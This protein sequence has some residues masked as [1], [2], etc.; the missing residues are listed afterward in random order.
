M[1]KNLTKTNNTIKQVIAR[2]CKCIAVFA[3]LFFAMCVTN[4]N[5]AEAAVTVS[6]THNVSWYSDGKYKINTGASY[7]YIVFESRAPW[8]WCQYSTT[9]SGVTG[10]KQMQAN[11]TGFPVPKCTANHYITVIFSTSY[12]EV[13]FTGDGDK[14]G[15]SWTI[16]VPMSK[17]KTSHSMKFE[18]SAT[19]YTDYNTYYI[20]EGKAPDVSNLTITNSSGGNWTNGTVDISV[21]GATDTSEIT[22]YDYSYTGTGDWKNDWSSNGKDGASGTW[23]AV[24]DDTVYFRACDKY[25][26][27]S[28][29]SS[30]TTKVRIEKTSPTLTVDV[31]TDG[32][33]ASS[34]YYSQLNKSLKVTLKDNGSPASLSSTAAFE[35]VWCKSPTDS[36]KCSGG[37]TSK[38]RSS[39][40]ATIYT[41]NEKATW[42]LWIK[43]SSVKD[44]AGNAATTSNT[45]TT[46]NSTAFVYKFEVSNDIPSYRVELHGVIERNMNGAN[47]LPNIKYYTTK[48]SSDSYLI[49]QFEGENLKK[50]EA[51]K[52]AA[53]ITAAN[54]VVKNNSDT[55]CK[56][57]LT[58][59][60]DATY[61]I[62]IASSVIQNQS[63]IYNAQGEVTLIVDG[64]KPKFQFSISDTETGLTTCS[65][66]NFCYSPSV[67]MIIDDNSLGES[68]SVKAQ[69]VDSSSTVKI[70]KD[71]VNV[72]TTLNSNTTKSDVILTSDYNKTLGS[73][74][75]NTKYTVRVQNF[76]DLAGNYLCDSKKTYCD[77]ISDLYISNVMPEVVV[78]YSRQGKG[79]SELSGEL[80]PVAANNIKFSAS[81]YPN[82][83][84][85]AVIAIVRGNPSVLGAITNKSETYTN[86]VSTASGRTG[87]TELQFSKIA[88]SSGY[89]FAAEI[90]VYAAWENASISTS[91]L[92]K[93]VT[94]VY[95]SFA[96][97]FKDSVVSAGNSIQ[98]SAQEYN[99]S[100]QKYDIY[101]DNTM[102][103]TIYGTLMD[104]TFGYN[105]PS[106]SSPTFNKLKNLV[107]PY[108]ETYTYKIDGKE[109]SGNEK[110]LKSVTNQQSS[111]E[112][113]IVVSSDPQKITNKATVYF[114]CRKISVDLSMSN[115]LDPNNIYLEQVSGQY[116]YYYVGVGEFKLT[117][118][119]IGSREIFE[120]VLSD[121]TTETTCESAL[122]AGTTLSHIA[123][124][125]NHSCDVVID[126]TYLGK[127]ITIYL[128]NDYN[129]FAEVEFKLVN[130]SKS[131]DS[132]VTASKIPTFTINGVELKKDYISGSGT[133]NVNSESSTLKYEMY[134]DYESFLS[135]TKTANMAIRLV[136]PTSTNWTKLNATHHLSSTAEIG[137]T[138]TGQYYH[139]TVTVS[140]KLLN[141]N[142]LGCSYNAT[143]ST[144]EDK[145]DCNSTGTLEYI[146]IYRSNIYFGEK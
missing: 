29:R 63:N 91:T 72:K 18:N 57:Q 139:E 134:L 45:C 144:D 145:V 83:K 27:C 73:Y 132:F 98:T 9:I 94:I 49:I 28:S 26:N 138:I 12:S 3:A 4:T 82:I 53:G 33:F 117:I 65:S 113:E 71:G 61:T 89:S 35:Y 47:S 6:S 1:S 125:E 86:F 76:S 67:K 95:D 104:T 34:T 24:R 103:S 77:V 130:L 58:H 32:S 100:T 13:K 135:R 31:P 121:G 84:V 16:E 129:M 88:K 15:Q 112:I 5:K 142:M 111:G 127:K 80:V 11:D 105:S 120:P 141:S 36:S 106:T 8:D 85:D 123:A 70:E 39:W 119:N 46:S 50:I 99:T 78:K 55:S 17:I 96:P 124:S 137:T 25:G 143:A 87:S 41:P 7:A 52:C 37:Y 81:N 19:S 20:I 38:S 118:T 136:A 59:S 10:K 2:L 93:T 75:L 54:M 107:K 66:S 30:K 14:W 115:T 69:L 51:G 97:K 60:F 62:K 79:D 102:N 40:S 116:L 23:S 128:S 43:K 56:V 48:G 90:T 133:I 122:T 22:G 44:A 101:I 110:V 42:Y 146:G 131:F 109:V 114:D 68:K 140:H 92:K 64:T 74:S 126:S 21:S 108:A